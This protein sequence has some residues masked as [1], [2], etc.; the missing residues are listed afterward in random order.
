MST[1]FYNN[2]QIGKMPHLKK[3][4]SFAMVVCHIFFDYRFQQ[5]RTSVARTDWDH[6]NKFESKVVTVSQG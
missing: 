6:E 5:C 2:A 4:L 1:L 3:I